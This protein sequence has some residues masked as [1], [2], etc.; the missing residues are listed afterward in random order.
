MSCINYR[1]IDVTA[2]P[3]GTP[4]GSDGARNPA[5]SDEAYPA[6]PNELPECL[7]SCGTAGGAT[8]FAV[9]AGLGG[10]DI[11]PTVKKEMKINIFSKERITLLYN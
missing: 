1:F 9:A 3:L 5:S 4:G 2:L 11:P 6:E 8:F 7:N 10:R